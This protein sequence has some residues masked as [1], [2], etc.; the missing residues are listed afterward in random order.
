MMRKP[1]PKMDESGVL[2]A[3]TIGFMIPLN[4]DV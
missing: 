1:L 3:S 4:P 2:V